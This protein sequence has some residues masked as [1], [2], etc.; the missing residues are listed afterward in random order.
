MS[1]V[2]EANELVPFHVHDHHVRDD[3]QA[4]LASR[5][6]QTTLRIA[7]LAEAR[8]DVALLGRLD[9]EVS[10]QGI[11]HEVRVVSV[12]IAA[13][14]YVSLPGCQQAQRAYRASPVQ[15]RAMSLGAPEVGGVG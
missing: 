10:G 5:V 6:C 12:R 15:V 1:S 7:R 3:G 4:V 14:E 8:H 9:L 2:A 11:L 13:D